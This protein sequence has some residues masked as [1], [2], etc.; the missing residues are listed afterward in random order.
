MESFHVKSKYFEIIHRFLNIGDFTK[1]IS[2]ISW[3]IKI[4]EKSNYRYVV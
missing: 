3:F 2:N 1:S 4:L